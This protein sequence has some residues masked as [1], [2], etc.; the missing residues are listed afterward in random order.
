MV[1]FAGPQFLQ[2]LL[3]ISLMLN[4]NN[5]VMWSQK[6]KI[7]TKCYFSLV[8]WVECKKCWFPVQRTA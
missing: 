3:I 4:G 6:D 2:H 5:Y 1:Y 8:N 7:K